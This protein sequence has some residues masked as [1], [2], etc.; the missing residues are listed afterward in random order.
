M[1]YSIN[2]D[3]DECKEKSDDDSNNDNNKSNEEKVLNKW[4]RKRNIDWR[5][6]IIRK[7]NWKYWK[8]RKQGKNNRK[9]KSK[10]TTNNHAN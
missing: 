6:K 9:R 7:T 3:D 1:R 4:T 2:F 8:L 5:K 10:K